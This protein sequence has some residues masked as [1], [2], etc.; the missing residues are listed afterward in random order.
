VHSEVPRAEA[1]AVSLVLA[2]GSGETTTV[3]IVNRAVLVAQRGEAASFSGRFD[4]AN[5]RSFSP[6][7]TFTYLVDVPAG[8]RDLDVNVRI[9]GVPSNQMIAHLSDPTGE[10]VVTGRNDLPGISPAPGQS[11]T[12]L[13]LVHANPVAGRWQLTLELANQSAGAALPQR[14]AGSFTLNG[15][16]V[17]ARGLP[18]EDTRISKRAGDTVKVTIEN[19]SPMPQTYFI[20]ARQAKLATY[21]LVAS[22]VAGDKPDSVNPYARTVAFPLAKDDVV[23][24]WLVPTQVR[25]LTVHATATEPIT[26][27]LMPLNSPTAIN[28][29]NN[30]DIESSFGQVV[31]AT[32]TA[33]EVGTSQWGA[34]PSPV[35]P[36]PAS[37]TPAGTVTMSAEV[38]ANAFDPAVTSS[39]GDPLLATVFANAAQANGITIPSGGEATVLVTITPTGAVGSE[40]RGTLYVDTLQAFGAQGFATLAE[41]VAALP[42]RYSVRR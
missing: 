42:Y 22:D 23:P 34:F 39:T 6:A 10:P 19:T 20:D 36:V 31:S 33:R 9:S 8:A 14:F 32:H 17:S 11:Y 1:S 16:E 13:Q 25:S 29:P 38:R 28:A 12:G 24:A 37:G 26:F 21:P 7:Q 18:G 2:H 41:E 40:Q 27:D 30:P 4:Q 15:A 5:G 3:P 35:G